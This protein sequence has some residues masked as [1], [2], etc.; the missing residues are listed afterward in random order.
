MEFTILKNSFILGQTLIQKVV[1]ESPPIYR[2]AVGY[3]EA[4]FV[5]RKELE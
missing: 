4:L 3:D 1:F 2:R 5:R